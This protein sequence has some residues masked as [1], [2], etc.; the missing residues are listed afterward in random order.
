MSRQLVF[1][2]ER[3]LVFVATPDDA[4]MFFKLWT[5][6]RVMSNVGF[7]QGLPIMFEEIVQQL[8]GTSRAGF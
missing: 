7:P 3:L 5:D 6:P 2:T 1:E 4:T 8:G